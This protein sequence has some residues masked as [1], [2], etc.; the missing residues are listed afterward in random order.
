MTCKKCGNEFDGNF[1]PFCGTKFESEDSGMTSKNDFKPMGEHKIRKKP[2]KK[3]IAICSIVTV[4]VMIST[5]LLLCLFN[6]INIPFLSDLFAKMIGEMK[7][8]DENNI[9]E[10][11]FHQTDAEHIVTSE[12]GFMYVDNEILLVASDTA[13]Y[14]DVEKLAK[15]YNA[16]IVGWIE[17]TAD[18]QLQF[19]QNYT[20]NELEEIASSLKESKFIQDVYANYAFETEATKT[21]GRNGFIYG[22]RWEDDLQHFN[23]CIGKSWGIEAIEVLASWDVLEANKSNVKPVKVGLVDSGFDTEHEDLGFA[24]TFYNVISD[25][26]THV[27]GTMAAKS[28]NAEGICGVYPY[29]DGNLYGVSYSGVCAYS[30]N[31]TPFTTSMFF[32]IAYSELILRNVKIINSSLGFNYCQWPLKYTDP[33]WENQVN[34]LESNAYI[35]GDFLKRLLD[36]GYDFVLVNAAGNDSNRKN[37]IV[38]DSK[39]SFWTTVISKEDYPEVYDRIIVVGA[40]NSDFKIR[41][42]SNGG[43]RVDIYAPGDKIFSTVPNNK[44]ENMSGTSMA[45]PHVSGVAAMVWSVNNDLT[46][47]QVKEI[48]CSSHSFRCKSCDMVDAYIALQRAA[49]FDTSGGSDIPENGGIL[50]WAV[51]AKNVNTRVQNATIIITDTQSGEEFITTTDSYGHFEFFVPAGKYSLSIKA[52]NYEDYFSPSDNFIVVENS[53]IKYLNDWVKMEPKYSNE[54][55]LGTY[56]GSYFVN[57]EEIGLTLTVYDEG[58]RYKATFEFYNLPGKANTKNGKYCM[59]VSYNIDTDEYFFAATEWIEQP[60]D[61]GTLDL[62]GKL[63]GNVLSGNSPTKFSVAK[64]SEN[65][66][67]ALAES[68]GIVSAWEYADYDG[69]GSK[70]AFAVITDEDLFIL[71]TLFISSEGKV[72]VI[73]NDLNRTLYTSDEGN[74]RYTEGKGFFW[75]DMGAGGSGWTTILYS[76]KDNNPYKLQLSRNIQGFYKDDKTFYTTE[77]DFLPEGG[78]IYP[79]I[80]LIYDSSSQEFSKGGNLEHVAAGSG[81]SLENMPIVAYDSYKDNEGDSTIFNL[82]GKGLTQCDDGITFN[83]Y[84]NVGVDG[85]TYSNGFEVWIARW[86][87]T[88]EISWASATFNLD[89]KYKTLTGKTGLIESYNTSNFDTTIYFYNGEKLLASYRLTNTDYIKNIYVDVTGVKNLKLYVKDNV[90]AS[91]GTSFALY[92]MFLG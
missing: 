22:E 32:K 76:V 33:E 67:K 91:G 25:H 70:E 45:A 60:A 26:G 52:E 62:E 34:F 86:N 78:H 29:G 15:K 65:G 77:N 56:R 18:F 13:E 79:N 49:H 89:G 68:H 16:E 64:A 35:L 41:D 43:D 54:E 59:D 90:A 83:R 73:E 17:Q 8:F 42:S 27:A 6:V 39:Y 21:E 57:E 47:A 40:V 2:K 5:V 46:G 44:Y 53:S 88:D 48:V 81:N 85:T 75:A 87:Y 30:E 36:L 71:E 11:Y 63:V 37:G 3:M 31:G 50:G 10:V 20:H 4:V 58:A 82:N 24:E 92:D 38:Y 66:L 1:C 28:N 80:E 69:N 55:I 72:T 9:G 7:T 84:G 14:K 61:Y 12:D 74:I 19:K 51:S 23:D